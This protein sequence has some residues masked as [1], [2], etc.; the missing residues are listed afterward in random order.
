MHN[1]ST[2]VVVGALAA[3]RRSGNERRVCIQAEQQQQQQ[4]T[5]RCANSARSYI[6]AVSAQR[7][8]HDISVLSRR[9]Q[10]LLAQ[11]PSGHSRRLAAYTT[12]SSTL[13]WIQS[14]I[15]VMWPHT[16]WSTGCKNV[17]TIAAQLRFLGSTQ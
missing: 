13:R 11:L 17:P 2:A 4:P 5:P 9:V 16:L 10:V 7:A 3:S 6:A 1:E 14:A 15:N 12:T 8:T